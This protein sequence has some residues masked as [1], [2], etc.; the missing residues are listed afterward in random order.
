MLT[1]TIDSN[2]YEWV[3]DLDPS[4]HPLSLSLAGKSILEYLLH[5]ARYRDYS[6]IAINDIHPN[7][8]YEKLQKFSELYGVKI[9]YNHLKKEEEKCY[10]A[11]ATGIGIFKDDG[12]FYPITSAKVFFELE[13]KLMTTPL[14]YSGAIGYQNDTN[15]QIGKDVYIHRSVKLIPPLIIGDNCILEPNVKIENS[16]INS[17]VHIE[18]DTIIKDSHIEKNLHISGN[19]YIQNK[20]LFA[21]KIYDKKASKSVAH[22]GVCHIT[23]E[24]S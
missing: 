16:V 6:S 9:I 18:E 7:I 17:N 5:W 23:K 15:M 14:A 4:L 13:A 21:L 12:I 22:D 19:L 10:L 11:D 1:I 24:E 3:T 8:T 2:S 20:A